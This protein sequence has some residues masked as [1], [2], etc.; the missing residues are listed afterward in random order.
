[1]TWHEF[2]LSDP[3]LD[4]TLEGEVLSRLRGRLLAFTVEEKNGSLVLHGMA[5]SYHVKQLAQCEVMSLTH[6]PIS[7]NNIKVDPRLMTS[8]R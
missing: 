1:M 2:L 6:Q 4:H 3:V 5:P 8:T 7:A